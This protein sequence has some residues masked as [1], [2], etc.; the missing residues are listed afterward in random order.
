MDDDGQICPHRLM[1]RTS[2]FQG[3][4]GDST[5]PGGRVLQREVFYIM[6]YK[7]TPNGPFL[8]LGRCPSG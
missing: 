1:V 3:G 2:L 7:K 4:N 8:G 5:S 6:Y